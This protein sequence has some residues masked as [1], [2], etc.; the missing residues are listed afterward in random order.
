MP[1][2]QVPRF[3]FASVDGT[4]KV[5]VSSD[6]AYTNESHRLYVGNDNVLHEVPLPA[7]GWGV[8]SFRG[9]PTSVGNDNC[10]V[11]IPQP[12]TGKPATWNS[13]T[14][15]EVELVRLPLADYTILEDGD[16]TVT[17]LEDVPYDEEYDDLA[18]E[19]E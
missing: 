17:I 7:D 10:G 5:Y 6:A 16:G 18:G 13:S 19:E 2:P 3:L 11:F 14:T 12:A 1:I 8:H 4:T 9:G 15:D